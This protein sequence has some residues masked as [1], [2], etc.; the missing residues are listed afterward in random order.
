[1]AKERKQAKTRQVNLLRVIDGDTVV[2]QRPGG[3]FSSH[4]K[5]RLRLW[6]IDAPESDQTGG[7]DATK[8]LK[9]IIGSRRKIWMTSMDTDHYGRTVAII[10]PDRRTLKNSYN[11]EMVRGG[12]AHTYMLAGPDQERYEKAEAE[13]QENRR[14]LWRRSSAQSPREFRVEQEQAQKRR[15]KL[16]WAL[17]A[18]G[19]AAVV[20]VYLYLRTPATG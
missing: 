13:A 2:V 14:G 10:H 11:Y 19:A 6:G 8:Y 5:E 16:K 4:P 18:L 1:M 7:K 15:R 12:H 3:W 20:T 17:I 9:R